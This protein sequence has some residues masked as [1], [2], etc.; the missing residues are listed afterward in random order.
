[1]GTPTPFLFDLDGT[2]ADTLP[3][4]AASLNHVRMLHGLA[5]LPL[6]S[7]RSCVGDGA[8]SLLRRGLAA[9]QPAEAGG[10]AAALERWLDD[11]FAAYAEHHRGQCTVHAR[12]YPG[13][14]PFLR[15]LRE[16][17]HRLGVVTNKPEPF[18]RP[19]LAHLGVADLLGAIV[20]GD[21]LPQRK[22]DPAPLHAALR[23][24]GAAG[25]GGTMVGD[26]VMDLQAGKAA[27][28]RTIACLYG[29]GEP[30]QLRAAGADE[31]WTA[32][33]TPPAPP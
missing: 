11:A 5:A 24:L 21:T 6:A 15:G 13:V 8:R 29:Y 26:G 27:G 7:V 19:L 20:G 2:L 23:T 1:L 17:G 9:A 16:R 31:F 30:V 10:D 32:F 12:L 18:A 14:L 3:D 28:L 4:I 22:P 25:G 33:G